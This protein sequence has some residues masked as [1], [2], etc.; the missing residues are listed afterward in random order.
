MRPAF[1]LLIIT[2]GRA[3]LLERLASALDVAGAER[4]AVLVREPQLG[5]AELLALSRQ[6]RA[7]TAARGARLLISDRLDVALA[8]NADGVQLPERGFDPES[9][10]ALLGPGAC[11]GVSR[12]GRP[13][14]VQAAKQGADYA[15]LSPIHPV[16]GKAPALGI[17]GFA[18]AIAGLSW[19]VYALG[20]VR[21]ADL[22]SLRAAG[23]R[24]VAVMREA[25]S[26]G[27]PRRSTEA[28]LAALEVR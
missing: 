4:I 24:G 19:P 15:T 27:D 28:L 1:D 13:G 26:A 14:L 20:G 9:A 16:E 2:D 21:S 25:L 6:A 17:A 3:Q 23:A 8:V 5:A 11:I 10:R 18:A 22:P 12:H 7:L